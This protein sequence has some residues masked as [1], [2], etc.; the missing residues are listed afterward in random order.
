MPSAIVEIIISHSFLGKLAN[1]YKSKH[2]NSLAKPHTYDDP[3]QKIPPS[4]TPSWMIVPEHSDG[5]AA[6]SNLDQFSDVEP[7]N[8]D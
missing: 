8:S 5:S 2:P 6:S 7:T 4:G 3:V 1:Q